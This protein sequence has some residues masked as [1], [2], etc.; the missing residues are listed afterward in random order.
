MFLDTVMMVNRY[1]IEYFE[2]RWP[3][4]KKGGINKK[5]NINWDPALANGNR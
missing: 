4:M 1:G 5:R 2:D 3:G